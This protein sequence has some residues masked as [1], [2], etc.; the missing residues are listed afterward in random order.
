MLPP[1]RSL[2]PLLALSL[3]SL[4]FLPAASGAERRDPGRRA[5]PMHWQDRVELIQSLWRDNPADPLFLM[6]DD[7]SEEE[8]WGEYPPPETPVWSAG[9][10]EPISGFMLSFVNYGGG[11]SSINPTFSGIIGGVVNDVPIYIYVA[12]EDEKTTLQNKLDADG[13]NPNHDNLIWIDHYLDSI[14]IRDFGPFVQWTEEEEPGIALVDAPYYPDGWPNNENYNSGYARPNDNDQPRHWAEYEELPRFDMKVAMEGGNFAPNGNGLCIVS[15][16]VPDYNPQFSNGEIAEMYRAFLGCQEWVVMEAMPADSTGHVDMWMTWLDSDTVMVGDYDDSVES[17]DPESNAILD[18]N[19]EI[20][21]SLT[22][23]GTGNPIEVVRVP[24]PDLY[25]IEYFGALYPVDRSYTNSF[26][27]NGK[28][29]MPVYT[30][31]EGE[32]PQRLADQEAEATAVYEAAGFE[33]IP[34]ES[35]VLIEWAGSI[36]C[37]TKAL[38][39]LRKEEEIPGDDD[40]DTHPGAD[41]DDSENPEDNAPGRCGGNQGGSDG[42]QK[43][44]AFLGLGGMILGAR[45]RRR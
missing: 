18:A 9:E 45:R 1:R 44:W 33:V 25:E 31:Q 42:P 34:V 7:T 13:T 19:A 21:A 17:N 41:D 23:P 24:M 5:A 12:S 35:T 8:P 3:P 36:H 29:L 40:D 11:S 27:V 28:V 38:P 32:D 43:I 14:W 37:I 20:F 39:L 6:G 15:S 2:L 10:F 4:T 30:A 16:I 22:D 26:M